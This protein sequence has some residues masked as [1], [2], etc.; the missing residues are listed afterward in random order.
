VTLTFVKQS[1]EPGVVT[2]QLAGGIL[3]AWSVMFGRVV[4]VAT[5]V[6]PATFAALILP[7]GA[8]ALASAGS[9]WVCFRMRGRAPATAAADVPIKNP[10][11]LW[12]ASKF[13]LLFA[14]VGLLLALGQEHFPTTGTYT[15]A[16]LAGLTDVDAVTL[17]MAQRVRA[18]P[19][20]LQVAVVAIVIATFANTL[21]KAGM[22]VVMGRSL[23]RP[24][25]LGTLAIV[26]AGAVT[27]WLG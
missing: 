19:E 14:L 20:D 11:S 25:A 6:A 8:M 13:A 1:R 9:A 10:F 12:A 18:M 23:G 26:L 17:S 7:F 22:A 24:V 2:T 3:L 27:L 4:V 16:A 15:V 21:V 5:V